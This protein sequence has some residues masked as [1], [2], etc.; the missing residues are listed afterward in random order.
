[1]STPAKQQT[2]KESPHTEKKRTDE[3][4]VCLVLLARFYDK[5]LDPEQLQHAMGCQDK[6]FTVEDIM[7]AARKSKFRTRCL[8]SEPNRIGK[9]T[10]VPGI[11]CLK[12]GRFALLLKRQ[13]EEQF[14]LG[15]PEE[16]APRLLT[17]DQFAEIWTGDII[18]LANRETLVGALRNFNIKWFIP[19]FIRYR[20][21]LSEVLLYSA[22]L[23]VL[24]LFIPIMFQQVIDR[25]L[26]HQVASTLHAI[27]I[28]YVFVI[29]F[30]LFFNMLRSAI[31]INATCKID[32]G[33]GSKLFSHL[34]RL[35]L[36]YFET[37]ATG[38]TVARVHELDSIR[39]F[40]TGSALS[41]ILDVPFIL[42][43]I[44]VMLF[45][46]PILTLVVLASIV[47]Y[48]VLAI[49]IT[50][51]LYSLTEQRFEK[52]AINQNFLIES[53]YGAATIKSM[54]I[55]PRM[56]KNW[57][58]KL[59]AFAETNARTFLLNDQAGHLVS[60]ISMFTTFGI[61]YLG[62]SQVFASNLSVGALIAFNML[63]G[64]VAQP[65]LR[66]AQLWQQ[67]QQAR[68]GVERLGDVL[69][70]PIEYQ[71]AGAATT[72][73]RLEGRISFDHVFFCYVN[74]HQNVLEDI[75]FDIK[76]GEIVGIVGPSGS[77]KSTLAKLI[78]RNYQ[79]NSGQ[80]QID[81]I[82]LAVIDPTQIRRQLGVV[83]QEN[84]LFNRTVR[85]NIALATPT[86][87]AEKVVEV[88][89][90]AGADSF[91]REM[92]MAYDTE[93]EERGQN[94]SGG[95]RQRLAIARALATDPRMLILDE[96][97]SALDHE[98]EA[99]IQAN[100]RQICKDRTVIII[101]HRLETLKFANRILSL[102]KGRLVEQGTPAELLRSGGF[103]SRV[104]ND[105]KQI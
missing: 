17:K 13:N 6:A 104:L 70:T 95:Q 19:E 93:I 85:D 69:N 55:E 22:A 54:S 98:S 29:A 20:A 49:L 59:A 32:V 75:S 79:P 62:T 35:P 18:L 37:R 42:I 94:L 84:M 80:I 65:I 34:L 36:A 86:I 25:V 24:Q 11:L 61:L 63:A 43:V 68:V 40:L 105:K 72:M 50:P 12:E 96:A 81:G 2:V 48:A 15:F 51:R 77:G 30:T 41:I 46:S 66:V 7:Q 27:A 103:Y 82:E 97:T 78:Q 53:I 31:L 28:A 90:L 38:Q 33:L 87:S 4:L 89:K 58:T 71:G 91:I 9:E 26:V 47:A 64:Q 1:M 101:T 57:D 10:P 21:Q 73:P 56:E 39:E 74:S 100:M 45:Y 99:A 92:P 102:E 5:R 67:F 76:A 52:G 16:D 44:S 3:G 83:P 60:A 14:L 8:S 23:I 88:A